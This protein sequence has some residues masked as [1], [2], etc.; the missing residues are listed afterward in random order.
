M[1]SALPTGA[2]AVSSGGHR[3]DA[4]SRNSDHRVYELLRRRAELIVAV[5]PSEDPACT[6]AALGNVVARARVDFGVEITFDDLET[7]RMRPGT[8]AHVVGRIHRPADR[9]DPG[10]SGHLVYVKAKMFDE[11]P[12]DVIARARSHPAFPHESTLAAA[13]G[14]LLAGHGRASAARAVLTD[15]VARAAVAGGRPDLADAE[16]VLALLA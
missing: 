11:A 9:D 6:F 2:P 12:A 4:R 14:R 13:P 3:R 7:S 5:D 10:W 8:P 15:P 1:A 16:A